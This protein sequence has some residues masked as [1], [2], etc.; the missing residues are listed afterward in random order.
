MNQIHEVNENLHNVW[1]FSWVGGCRE[2]NI[3]NVH[4]GLLA[5]LW[6]Y[7]AHVEYT[8]VFA[9]QQKNTRHISCFFGSPLRYSADYLSYPTLLSVIW[10]LK[11][12][13]LL[14]SKLWETATKHNPQN[15]SLPNRRVHQNQ[16]THFIKYTMDS[17]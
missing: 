4:G 3:P 16:K 15:Y 5:E 8:I 13:C 9:K 12:V 2:K 6:R 1:T 17:L 14:A 10:Q 11:I 7:L